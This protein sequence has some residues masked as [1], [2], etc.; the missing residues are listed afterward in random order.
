MIQEYKG[1]SQKLNTLEKDVY[2]L[3]TF[4]FFNYLFIFYIIF[5]LY[6]DLTLHH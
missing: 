2:Y 5:S 6:G 1:R 3:F 4:L